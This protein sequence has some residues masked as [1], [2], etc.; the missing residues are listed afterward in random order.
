LE[1][2]SPVLGLA[3]RRG[4]GPVLERRLKIPLGRAENL[5]PEADKL[6]K[7]CRLRIAGVQTVLIGRGPGSFTGLRIGFSTLKG[8]RTGGKRVACWGVNSLDLIARNVPAQKGARLCVCVDARRERCYV[9]F[10][11]GTA[12]GWKG[13]RLQALPAEAIEAAMPEGA[14]AAGDGLKRYDDLFSRLERTKQIRRLP[15]KTW[16]PRASAL[17]EIFEQGDPVIKPLRRPKDFL[18]LYGRSGEPNAQR[19]GSHGTVA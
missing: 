13:G 7:K 16:Y 10:Y 17:I 15:E 12:D 2:S 11:R 8:L 14:A 4:R 3:V 18:P 1:T 19:K 6:L 9:K 5:I